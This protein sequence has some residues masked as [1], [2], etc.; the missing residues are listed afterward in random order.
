MLLILILSS[1]FYPIHL[2]R[3]KEKFEKIIFGSGGGFTGI[4]NSYSL[5]S[6]GSLISESNQEIIKT[7]N[8]KKLKE[9]NKK[10]EH[11]NVSNLAF[12]KPGNFYYF[13]EVQEKGKAN[14]VTW[15]DANKAPEKV[16]Q[17]Y[18]YLI[19]LTK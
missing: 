11:S 14:R 13:I 16:I 10:I 3:K 17:L 18:Q 12:N 9:L 19:D 6:K 15:S 1:A 5:N 8:S 4:V 2:E 7:I